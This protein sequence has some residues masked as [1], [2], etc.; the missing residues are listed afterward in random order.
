MISIIQI[1]NII[2]EFIDTLPSSDL[3]V[4]DDEYDYTAGY[5]KVC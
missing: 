1:K 3:I 4:Y 2:E 5:S